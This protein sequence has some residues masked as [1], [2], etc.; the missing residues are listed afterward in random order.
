M[1][2]EAQPSSR[3]FGQTD[4]GLFGAAVP[5]G[6]IAGDQQ[7]ALFGQTCFHRGE[8]KSTYG[9]GCFLLLNTGHS[10]VA[11]RN[12]LLTTIA[13][14]LDGKVTYALEG[15][16]F[17][18]G[19]AIQWL[20]DE[21]G[22]IRD[23][24]QS[25]RC[26]LEVPDTNGVYFVPAFVGLGAPYWDPYA[27]GIIVGLTRGANRNHLIRA[28]LESIAYQTCDVLTAMEQDSGVRLR[29]LRVDG[30]ASA[31]DFLMQFQSDLIQGEV[32]RP[33]CI[34]TT[35][36]GA[37]YLAGLSAGFWTDLDDIKDNWQM[38]GSFIP[39]VTDQKSKELQDEWHRAI[40][41]A[42]SWGRS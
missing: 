37:A 39:A 17:I 36:L 31:N 33:V 15:S 7:A 5:I 10:P 18:G 8:A 25:E 34:Q 13:W 27:R 2:P 1:L 4:P 14:G 16:I 22:L 20:R 30:G 11:S 32:Q 40:R 26:A 12:G 24:A 42:M 6:G 29:T 23:A 19:A 41:C 28:A 9:T 3:L 35:A 38:S 21:M